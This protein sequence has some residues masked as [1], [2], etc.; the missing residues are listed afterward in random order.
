MT[1][2]AVAITVLTANGAVTTPA[3]VTISTTNGANIARPTRGRKMVVRITNTITDA[4]KTATV[5]AG[6]SP[7][8]GRAGLG[9][10]TVAI[11]ASDERLVC[12]ETARFVQT[13]GTIN[14][15]FSAG[16]TG[17]I[18]AIELPQF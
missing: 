13:D 12:L 10:L 17:K 8:A 11:P 15:D 6:A 3:G 4:T 7:P 9:D 14:V 16:M 5:K 18:S 1:R 2:D